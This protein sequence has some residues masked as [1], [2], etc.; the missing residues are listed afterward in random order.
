ME[1]SI[2]N[3]FFE[4]SLQGNVI[5]GFL[6]IKILLLMLKNMIP[7]NFANGLSDTL[8]KQRFHLLR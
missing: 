5:L 8:S 3:A 2:L 4:T 1:V 7:K 6:I